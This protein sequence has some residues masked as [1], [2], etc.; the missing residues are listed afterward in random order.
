M[1]TFWAPADKSCS[2]CQV[3][4]QH[5]QELLGAFFMVGKKKNQLLMGGW[6]LEIIVCHNSA[7]L[8]MPKGDPRDDFSSPEPKA[9][10]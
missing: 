1:V 3:T 10:R 4:S 2:S 6:D 9:P 7:S 5:I 8:V